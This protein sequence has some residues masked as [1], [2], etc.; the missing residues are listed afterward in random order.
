M[1]GK[2]ALRGLAR[3][4]SRLDGHLYSDYRISFAESDIYHSILITLE[5]IC[6]VILMGYVQIAYNLCFS[7]KSM[8]GKYKCAIQT[9]SSDKDIQHDS[10]GMRNSPCRKSP[11]YTCIV[12][13]DGNVEP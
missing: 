1:L 13:F 8:S 9:F 6:S 10:V 12:D 5:E 7:A 11:V 2:V 4:A 3:N